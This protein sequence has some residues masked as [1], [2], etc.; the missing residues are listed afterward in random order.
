MHS[1]IEKHSM[2]SFIFG[3]GYPT[4]FVNRAH[5]QAHFPARGDQNVPSVLRL[6]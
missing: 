6:L 2:K 5:E 4:F 3:N 1:G